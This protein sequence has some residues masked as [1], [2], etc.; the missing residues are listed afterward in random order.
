ML[1]IAITCRCA[2]E[3]GQRNQNVGILDQLLHQAFVPTS[4]RYKIKA[5]VGAK[6]KRPLLAVHQIVDC[7]DPESRIEQMLAQD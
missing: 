2:D 5:I 3:R 7:G 6:M 1:G 4:P